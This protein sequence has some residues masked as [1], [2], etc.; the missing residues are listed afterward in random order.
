M[1]AKD[2]IHE[3]VKTALIKDGWTITNDPYT[4]EFQDEFLYADLGAERV[5][6]AQ[7]EHQKIVV[8]CKSFIK[9][10][11]IQDF[12]E[13]LGQYMI[14]LPLLAQQAPNHRLYIAVDTNAYQSA[15]QRQIVQFLIQLHQIPLIIVDLEKPEISQWIS[16]PNIVH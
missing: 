7:R 5:I 13:A 12:K 9:L 8:E 16:Y 14:Y 1:S 3:A 2:I 4:I 15:F 11:P 10:S 6:A